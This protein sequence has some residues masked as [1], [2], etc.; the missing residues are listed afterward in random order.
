M[1]KGRKVA[2]LVAASACALGGAAAGISQSAASSSSNGSSAKSPKPGQW[3]HGAR[4]FGFAGHGGPGFGD[5]VHAVEV[6]LNKAGTAYITVTREVGTITA[7]DAGASKITLKEG[8]SSVTYA[9]PT[10]SIP[11]GST[12]TLDGASSSLEKLKAGE[13]VSISSS[14]E[15][16]AVFAADS[17]FKPGPPPGGMGG[18]PGGAPNGGPQNAPRPPG[19]TG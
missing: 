12:V 7:V 6:V 10:I 13:D 19:E 16:T 15:G 18:A 11:S 8:T 5:E 3:A 4:G 14:S 9:T 1:Q 17:S 2:V